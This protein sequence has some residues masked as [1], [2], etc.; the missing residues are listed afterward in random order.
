MFC[1]FLRVCEE[2]DHIAKY[3][4]LSIVVSKSHPAVDKVLKFII[5]GWGEFPKV[6]NPFPLGTED[7]KIEDLKDLGKKE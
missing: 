1:D 3:V 7:W 5:T 4:F 2:W 6:V